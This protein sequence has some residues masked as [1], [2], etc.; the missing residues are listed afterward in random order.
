MRSGEFRAPADLADLTD[1]AMALLDGTGLRALLR[2]P[3]MDLARARRLAAELLGAELGVDPEELIA[4][5]G[6]LG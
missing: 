5:R 2:D 3:E 6:A 1:R 4:P